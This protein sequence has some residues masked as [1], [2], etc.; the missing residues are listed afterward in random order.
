MT[1]QAKPSPGSKSG[2]SKAKRKRKPWT[3]GVSSLFS[4]K[5]PEI[6]LR[7]A[8][9][10]EEKTH[11][12]LDGFAPYIR[13][14]YSSCSIVNFREEDD[15][16][17]KKGSQQ[18]VSGVIPKSSCLQL[19]RVS[20][21]A[22]LQVRRFCCLCGRAGNVEGLGDLHGPYYSRG[23]Q[24]V[25]KVDRSP[26]A[27]KQDA[28]CSDPESVCSLED[29]ASRAVPRQRKEN[30]SGNVEESG[31]CA[32]LWIHE[33]CSIWTAGI[34]LVKGKLYGLEEAIRLA[35][36]T[37]CSHCHMVGATL[38]CF[39]KDCPNKYHFPCALQ[40]DSALNEENFTMRCPKHKVDFSRRLKAQDELNEGYPGRRWIILTAFLCSSIYIQHLH[41]SRHKESPFH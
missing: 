32:E 4:P 22:S 15:N 1:K 21:E 30:C 7:Y 12:R 41:I 26:E 19:G 37:V 38:G 34:F 11:A 8:N 27:Q 18:T 10:K 2:A 31:V 9:H 35:Q 23:A 6:K 24:P 39:F 3:S 16:S 17:T 33:D 28:D 14:K 29:G 20:S 5:E 40:S 25:C 36:G 13:M